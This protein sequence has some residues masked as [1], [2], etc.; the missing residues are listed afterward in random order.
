ME[1]NKI[2]NLHRL[3]F[4]CLWFLRLWVRF[5]LQFPTFS[6]EIKWFSAGIQLFG[7]A[8]NY[9]QF[10]IKL[11]SAYRAKE[12]LHC[13]WSRALCCSTLIGRITLNVDNFLKNIE[14]QKVTLDSLIIFHFEM[15]TLKISLNFDKSLQKRG[16]RG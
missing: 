5:G 12:L 9:V 15:W 3:P 6:L 4:S 2:M 11:L 16:V 8:P 14:R 7:R 1:I 13:D 10:S